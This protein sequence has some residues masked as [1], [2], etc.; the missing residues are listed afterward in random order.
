MNNMSIIKLYHG[1]CLIEGRI[2]FDYVEGE[3]G[4][5]DKKKIIP[6]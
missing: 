4:E 2:K 5:I 6:R 1:D 3:N